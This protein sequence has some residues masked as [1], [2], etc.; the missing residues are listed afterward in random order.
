ME[1]HTIFFVGKPGSG[2]GTQAALLAEKTEWSIVGTSAGMR[3]MIAEGAA[4]G[5]KLKETMDSGL[6]TPH[7]LASHIYLKAL[8]AVPADGSIIFDGT[9]RTLPEAEVV[10]AALTWLERPYTILHLH[11]R[12]E[13]VKSRIELRKV[14]EA[15]ADDH[16]FDKRL[17]EYYTLTEPAINYYRDK[18]VLTEVHGEGAPEDIAA[19]I[20]KILKI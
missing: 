15:R 20:R 5:Q 19:E 6:L 16:K 12:D 17:E 8:F 14:K 1:P 7:W 2:K 11:T 4:V 18:G 13:E 10:L 9:S 3:E